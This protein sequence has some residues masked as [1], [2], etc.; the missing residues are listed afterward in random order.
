MFAPNTCVKV[1]FCLSYIDVAGFE[2]ERRQ[3]HT[4]I[5]SYLKSAEGICSEIPYSWECVL[6]SDKP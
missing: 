1:S 5:G 6:S 4:L 2:K 3:I